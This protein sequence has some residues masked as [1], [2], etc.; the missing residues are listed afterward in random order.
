MHST[1]VADFGGLSRFA[2]AYVV[3][4]CVLAAQEES[5]QAISAFRSASRLMPGDHRPLV[6]LAKELVQFIFLMAFFPPTCT[7]ILKYSG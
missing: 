1:N 4:G 2:R 7:L 3:L 5:E 6:L